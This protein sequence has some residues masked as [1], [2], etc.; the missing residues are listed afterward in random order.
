MNDRHTVDSINSDQLDQLYD[1]LARAETEN[2]ELRDALA[3]CHEREP[4]QRAEAAIERVR[5]LVVQW[6][7]AGPP[8]LGVSVS[9]WWDRRLVELNATLDD[10]KDQP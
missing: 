4:R 3:H 7:K 8:P 9:R 5:A 2:A 1:D 10:P 6:A